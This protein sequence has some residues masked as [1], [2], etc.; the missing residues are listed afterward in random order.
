MKLALATFLKGRMI[1]EQEPSWKTAG[2]HLHNTA[3]TTTADPPHFICTD[4]QATGADNTESEAVTGC[5]NDS[6]E[7]NGVRYGWQDEP[8]YDQLGS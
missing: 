6:M 4:Q 8:W 5:C 7:H 2:L 3:V 1:C